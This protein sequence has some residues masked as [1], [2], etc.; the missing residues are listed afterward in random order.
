MDAV[1]SF[2]RLSRSRT[3]GLTHEADGN[4]KTDLRPPPPIP[5]DA[6][7]GYNT[8]PKNAAFVAWAKPVGSMGPFRAR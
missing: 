5:A 4:N 2:P 1:V 7:T 3:R 8:P 6:Q